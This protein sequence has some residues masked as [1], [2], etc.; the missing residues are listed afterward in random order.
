M[1]S[2][3]TAFIGKTGYLGIFLLMVA[4]N[5]FPPIPSEMIMP[6]AGYVAAEGTLSLP[7]V[8][9]AG[10]LGSLAGVWVWYELARWL[11]AERLRILAARHGR[12]LTLS[13]ADLDRAD[14]WFDAHAGKMVLL[15]RL[16]PGIRT[17]ISIPA[18]VFGMSRLAFLAYSALGT[19][20]W[21]AALAFA[22]YHLRADFG[23]V[24]AYVDPVSTAVMVILVGTYLY[25]VATWSPHR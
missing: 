1:L 9:L 15:G 2:T 20:I 3:I 12:W 13:P 22:G 5:I 8:V 18:G 25:R 16:I 6:F 4:E 7:I 19:A 14:V 21:A 17:L 24:G 11:G 10:A 23:D